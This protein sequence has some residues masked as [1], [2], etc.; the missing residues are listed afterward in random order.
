MQI[1]P[2]IS[3][4][5]SLQLPSGREYTALLPYVRGPPLGTVPKVSFVCDPTEWLMAYVSQKPYCT[6]YYCI[7]L[8]GLDWLWLVGFNLSGWYSRDMAWGWY[9]KSGTL[10]SYLEQSILGQLFTPG[11]ELLLKYFL[12]SDHLLIAVTKLSLWN[13][14]MNTDSFIYHLQALTSW[15]GDHVR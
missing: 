14:G 4:F 9:S 2:A 13:L 7:G 3:T 15:L 11:S 8:Y 5:P 6:Q 12:S 10:T 1:R